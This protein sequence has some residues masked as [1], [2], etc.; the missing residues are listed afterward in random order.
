MSHH[1]ETPVKLNYFKNK[2]QVR[3][4]E[5]RVCKWRICKRSAIIN[6][7]KMERDSMPL[8]IEAREIMQFVA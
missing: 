4:L 3:E 5:N 7:N 6:K 1:T 2:M 8:E